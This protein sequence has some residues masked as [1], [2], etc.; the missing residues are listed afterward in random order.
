MWR[1]DILAQ[2]N[3]SIEELKEIIKQ[4]ANQIRLHEDNA[5]QLRNH[6]QYLQMQVNKL[7][8]VD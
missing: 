2:E 1:Y 6:N 4:Q 5:V 7:K 3:P 8:D